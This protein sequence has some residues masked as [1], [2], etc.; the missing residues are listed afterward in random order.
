M[1]KKV[2]ATLHLSMFR[3]CVEIQDKMVL[4]DHQEKGEIMALKVI[5]DQKETRYHHDT[6]ILSRFLFSVLQTHVNFWK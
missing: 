1:K 2:S 5:Q 4:R 3:E 6:Y